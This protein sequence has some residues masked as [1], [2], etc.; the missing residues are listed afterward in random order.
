MGAAH[1]P[2]RSSP[3]VDPR[4]YGR[5][6]ADGSAASILCYATRARFVHSSPGGTQRVSFLLYI[7]YAVALVYS[8]LIIMRAVL[9]WF[10][11]SPS[12]V[13]HSIRAA[14]VVLTEPYLRLFR[15]FVPMAR[16]GGMGFDLSVL[17]GLVVLFVVI[18]LLAR[19]S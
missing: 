13:V 16:V 10:P 6:R 15:R 9:S 7:L 8:W 12:S 17:V 18:Q 14:L 1:T 4:L 2:Q 11:A 3:P 19:V 5:G